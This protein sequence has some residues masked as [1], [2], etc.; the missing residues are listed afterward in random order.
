MRSR[1]GCVRSVVLY[2]WNA[3]MD[4]GEQRTFMSTLSAAIC[5][6]SASKTDKAMREHVRYRLGSI[7]ERFASFEHSNAW[8]RCSS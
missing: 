5:S 2:V 3:V 1:C 8:R 6:D 4:I 7:L